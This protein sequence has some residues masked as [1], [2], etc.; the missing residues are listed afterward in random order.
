MQSKLC[1]AA[2]LTTGLLL[3]ACASSPFG[4]GFSGTA[5]LPDGRVD[6]SAKM[7]S[8]E[9][10][11]A[12]VRAAPGASDPAVL[13]NVVRTSSGPPIEGMVGIC[14]G[15]DGQ[16]YNIMQDEIRPGMKLIFER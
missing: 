11:A 2:L 15:P 12:A 7:A 6:L 3:G 16:G 14:V 1:N 13:G 8:L 5:Y 4:R 9:E 10:C